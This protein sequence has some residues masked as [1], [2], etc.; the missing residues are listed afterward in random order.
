VPVYILPRLDPA[1]LIALAKRQGRTY[2]DWAAAAGMPRN[3]LYKRLYEP[4]SWGTADRLAI[5][6]GYHPALVWGDKW[7][8]IQDAYDQAERE[9]H[10][11]RIHLRQ[12]RREAA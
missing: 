12:R 9:S 2:E 3:S 6:L 5:A 7:W 11:R 10:Q 8:Q 1:P 4:L